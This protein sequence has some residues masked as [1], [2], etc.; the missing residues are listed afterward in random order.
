[1]FAYLPKHLLLF[2]VS[3]TMTS[4]LS[5]ITT[6]F[7]FKQF[8]IVKYI[9]S[10]P[11]DTTEINVSNLNLT[12]LPDLSRFD[13]LKILVC[14]NNNLTLLP[15]LNNSLEYLDCSFNKLTKLP[16]FNSTLK[17][18]DCNN[19]LLTD[20]QYLNNITVLNC[21]NNPMPR[22]PALNTKLTYINC[23]LLC[24]FTLYSNK[25]NILMNLRFTF[26]CLKLK[27]K[28]KKWL[29]EKVR[30]PKVMAKFHPNH[31]NE[32]KDIDDLDVF[33]EDWIKE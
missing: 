25:I 8:D 30:E 24:C 11:S 23:D 2:K 13:K 1:M 16:Q 10:L 18:L 5:K 12:F 27:N 22:L 15:P 7:N 33:L 6:C 29:W 26:Y 31:L 14:S 28:F 32:L 19:N 3:L 4:L 17:R 9:N 20:L 21:V